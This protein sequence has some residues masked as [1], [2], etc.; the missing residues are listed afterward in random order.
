MQRRNSISSTTSH[1]RLDC[2]RDVRD[3][4]TDALLT[5]DDRFLKKSRK[6]DSHLHLQARSYCF[7]NGEVFRPRNAPTKR[8]KPQK[9]P[10]ERTERYERNERP[11]RVDIP[12][13]ASMVLVTSI[14]SSHSAVPLISSSYLTTLPSFSN[15]KLKNKND[16]VLLIRNNKLDTPTNININ[17]LT[18]T[19]PTPL[20]GP[21]FHPRLFLLTN[22]RYSENSTNI[23]RLEL[24]LRNTLSETFVNGK[25]GSLDLN[26][27][28]LSNYNLNRSNSNTPQTSVSTSDNINDTIPSD[29]SEPAASLNKTPSLELIKE[30]GSADKSSRITVGNH[31]ETDLETAAGSPS[32][33]TVG[34]DSHALNG[35]TSPYESLNVQT[36]ASEASAYDSATDYA[37]AESRKSQEENDRGVPTDSESQ[38]PNSNNGDSL[39][40]LSAASVSSAAPDS[41]SDDDQ[42]DSD[43]QFQPLKEQ[44]PFE[45][46]V[47]D[48]G[49]KIDSPASAVELHSTQVVSSGQSDAPTIHHDA[50]GDI[51]LESDDSRS[52]N[53]QRYSQDY[54][55]NTQ[56]TTDTVH[57]FE[58]GP[59]LTTTSS[60]KP[61]DLTSIADTMNSDL[62]EPTIKLDSTSKSKATSNL[63]SFESMTE[64]VAGSTIPGSPNTFNSYEDKPSPISKDS[65]L[66]EKP[67]PVSK[68]SSLNERPSPISKDSPIK[69]IPSPISKDSPKD[70]PTP[71]SKDS[72]SSPRQKIRSMLD[73]GPTIPAT[74]VGTLDFPILTARSA[75]FG[76][77]MAPNDKSQENPERTLVKSSNPLGQ[78]Q[79]REVQPLLLPDDFNELKLVN[80]E[81]SK[82]K[83]IDLRLNLQSETLATVT[84]VLPDA[85]TPISKDSYQLTPQIPA[86]GDL[87]AF[88]EVKTPT[89]L[90]RRTGS[91][92][93]IN[94]TP[95]SEFS[96]GGGEDNLKRKSSVSDT[97]SGVNVSDLY[98]RGQIE[99]F[100]ADDQ[101]EVPPRGDLDIKGGSIKVHKR[102]AS[103]ISSL[104]SV[105]QGRLPRLEVEPV[106][107]P[108][109]DVNPPRSTLQLQSRLS[110]LNVVDV[111]FDKSL[112]PTPERKNKYTGRFSL[113]GDP[114]AS[115]THNRMLN[116]PSPRKDL[117][118]TDEGTLD[119]PLS[120]K[121]G[122]W[123]SMSSFKKVFKRFGS[124]GN[125]KLSKQSVK[126]NKKPEKKVTKKPLLPSLKTL[127]TSNS[128]ISVNGDSLSE[129]TIRQLYQ[130]KELPVQS[131]LR[132]SSQEDVSFSTAKLSKFAAKRKKFVM[133][134]KLASVGRIEELPSPVYSVR[135]RPE[136]LDVQPLERQPSTKFDLPQLEIGN[137]NFDDL[138]LKFD[139]VEQKAEK[140]VEELYV[141]PKSLSSL[142]LKDDELTEAQIVDQQKND[143]QLSDESLPRAFTQESPVLDQFGQI[144]EKLNGDMQQEE[145]DEG[146]VDPDE[147]LSLMKSEEL[148]VDLPSEDG[149]QRIL[150]KK[151]GLIELLAD[152]TNRGLPAFLKHVK[153]FQDFPEI[154]IRVSDFDPTLNVN[155]ATST[156]VVKSPILKTEAK[157]SSKRTVEFSNTISI[158]ETYP[159]YMYKR[160]NKSVTQYYLTEFAEVNR[161][162]NELNA[163][164]CHEMLVHEKSQMNTH[165]FY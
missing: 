25:S 77:A 133:S 60:F 110:M 52:E 79:P 122:K 14:N 163:Y 155:G 141:N 153:Q 149:E 85:P 91:N 10:H 117:P 15:L 111:D 138:L 119:L 32:A 3:T 143:N 157:P 112:P 156:A 103:S 7:P 2:V 93:Q 11:D 120:E 66:Q 144:E 89:N 26:P 80:H 84:E 31:S 40:S 29:E 5:L 78:S 35:G 88:T 9:I 164:K 106:I 140:E 118:S 165:F 151:E 56:D 64:Y 109:A 28:S 17:T 69:E 142:F 147:T 8:N 130:D 101:K 126:D 39:I 62:P 87:A 76:T 160:Y 136:T 70:K 71:I 22:N 41:S 162:K 43:E 74:S 158:S 150:L 42:A 16:L 46:V 105:L 27:S 48:S 104:N 125:S 34:L 92:Q 107:K 114:L 134:L 73:F 65:P 72:P 67:L 20:S 44:S 152:N 33:E 61:S 45:V 124:E 50:H 57:S 37:S 98:S 59:D 132:T 146:W 75:S 94:L 123:H 19:P 38:S 83:N 115:P 121:D 81:Y 139:E 145:T 108:A 4:S 63:R 47:D 96:F 58:G 6:S 135:D 159:S 97:E 129:V 127:R 24:L 36:P 54:T 102:N 113:L 55:L 18:Q 13:S 131:L 68:D 82:R 90:P 21:Q 137:D 30:T 116:K 12:R 49:L 86:R 99:K 95:G 161:I 23:V 53:S 128:T 100:L 148:V 154:E 1:A 51:V